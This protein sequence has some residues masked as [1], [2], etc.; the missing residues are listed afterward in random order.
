[1]PFHLPRINKSLQ[2]G[3][4]SEEISPN[5]FIA[6]GLNFSFFNGAARVP[7][8]NRPGRLAV[9]HDGARTDDTAPT[10][11]D[12]GADKSTAGDPAFRFD[13]D[14]FVNELEVRVRGVVTPC[15]QVRVL[16]DN[17]HRTDA[18]FREIEQDGVMPQGDI[19]TH[20]EIP[21]YQ[22]IDPLL[23]ITVSPDARAEEAK[24]A[25]TKSAQTKRN[26]PVERFDQALPYSTLD[27]RARGP[28]RSTLGQIDLVIILWGLF[29][30]DQPHPE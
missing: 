7:R 20:F 16:R 9:C 13:R 26:Q 3:D 14:R 23:N 25:D 12:A 4:P 21:W 29:H 11:G 30:L 17:R 6:N 1:I 10:K 18:D 8:A 2:P 19:I 15:A 28:V 27:L 5:L 24:N 22:D